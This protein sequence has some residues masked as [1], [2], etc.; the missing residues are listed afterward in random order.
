[1][2]NPLPNILAGDCLIFSRPG[3]FDFAIK[4]KTWSPACHVE[5]AL[6]GGFTVASRNGKG[7]ARYPIDLDGLYCVL[8]PLK[9]FDMAAAMSSFWKNHNGKPYGWLALLSFC[10]IDLHD[11]GE[12][13]SELGTNFYRDG[14]FEP[15]NESI[16]AEIVAPSDYLYVHRSVMGLVWHFGK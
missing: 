12:F 15:F 11:K 3:L 5:V 13:C 6:G 1:M 7:V 8:R 2:P 10:L 9:N 4:L 14:G 16:K